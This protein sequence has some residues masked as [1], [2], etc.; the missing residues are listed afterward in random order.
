[1][2]IYAEKIRKALTGAVDARKLAEAWAALHPSD[3]AAK[4]ITP[5]MGPF[6][7]RANQAIEAAL[8]DVLP[9]A[10]AEGWALGQQSAQALILDMPEVDWAGWVP[11]DP[12][13]A[14][15]VAGGGLRD[16]LAD[17]EIT[18]KSIASSRLEE[19]GDI[20]AEYI[21]ST[22]AIRPLLPAPVPPMFSVDA[23]AQAL[24]GVLDNPSRAYMVAQSE[25]ARA[26]G[27]AAEWSFR[28]QGLSQEEIST[29]GDARVC[30]TCAAAE[31][32]GPQPI[33]TYSLGLH[34]LCRCAKIP[35]PLQAPAMAGAS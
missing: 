5:G 25:I 13:A 33:G 24:K 28:Q 14:R 30:P 18:I 17:Q 10:W 2:D 11:G 26:Q 32:A 7:A 22:E 1:M 27:K 9:D 6:R 3:F 29:A 8:R 23:L 16:L 34:P 15:Q 31:Q 21:G 4:G 12:D 19:L 20:L 35:V